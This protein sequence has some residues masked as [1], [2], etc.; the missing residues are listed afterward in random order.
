MENKLNEP[1]AYTLKMEVSFVADKEFDMHGLCS[2]LDGFP[3]QKTGFNAHID[4][5]LDMEPIV[6]LGESHD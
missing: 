3:F 2:F 1:G 5:G 6:F 4:E